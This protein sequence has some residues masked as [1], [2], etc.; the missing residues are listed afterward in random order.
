MGQAAALQI[1]KTKEAIPKNRL[2]QKLS[3]SFIA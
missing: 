1:F 2:F 3:R